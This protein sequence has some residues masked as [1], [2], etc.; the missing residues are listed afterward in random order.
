MARPADKAE[1][2]VAVNVMLS[3]GERSPESIKKTLLTPGVVDC[4]QTF[5]A[6]SDNELNRLYILKVKSRDV[7]EVIAELRR[8]AAIEY[9]EAAAKRRLIR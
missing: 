4:E 2:L 3:P 7:D 5:P 1:D 8:S 9:A 6:D